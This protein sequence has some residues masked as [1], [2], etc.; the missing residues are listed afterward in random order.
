M[1]LRL[2]KELTTPG[3]SVFLWF[4]ISFLAT[5]IIFCLSLL[6]LI[7]YCQN[8][9]T[10]LELKKSSQQL[11]SGMA[12]VENTITSVL[13]SSQTLS[14]DPR[15]IPLRY[16]EPDYIS[17][18]VSVRNQMKDY[19]NG[20]VFPLPLVKDCA[21]QFTQDIAVTTHNTFF[22]DYISYYPDFFCVGDLDNEAWLALLAENK[23]GFLPVQHV[24]SKGGE[25]IRNYQEYDALIYSVPWTKSSFIYA[26]LDV[27][28]IKRALIAESD[29]ST[30]FLSLS[31]SSGS[32]LYSDCPDT[33]LSYHTIKKQSSVG[34][35]IATIH[36]PE[37]EF[38]AKMK[39]LYLF[40][41]GYCSIC[42]LVL[43]VTIIISSRISTKPLVNIIEMLEHSNQLQ[44]DETD[45]G[46]GDSASLSIK[47]GFRYIQEHFERA[48]D[49]LE[50]YHNTIHTQRRVLQARFLEKALNSQLSNARDKEMFLTYFPDFPNHFCL[51]NLRLLEQPD[52]NGSIYPDS[53][54]ILQ[55]FLQSELPGAYQQQMNDIELLLIISKGD[56]KNYIQT[57][58]YLIN[59]INHEEPSYRI[60]GIASSFYEHLENLPTAYRQLQDLNGLHFP[61]S[62]SQV[63]TFNDRPSTPED[64][65]HMADM[66]TLYTA[67]NYGNC[68]LALQR[69]KS[70]SRKLNDANR[71]IYE[72]I[73]SILVCIKM[74]HPD[75]LLSITIPD[76]S[77]SKNLYT[78]LEKTICSFCQVIQEEKHVT[79]DPFVL[80]LMDYIDKHFREYGLCLAALEE[81]FNCS[82]SKI[83]K[84]F[85]NNLQI[86]VS[87][88]IEKKRME[89]A[90]ELL[91]QKEKSITEIA[92]E[93]GFSNS[94][95]FYK[96]YQRVYGINPSAVKDSAKKNK[97]K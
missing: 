24:I 66:L 83:Q 4:L 44:P 15:F 38:T 69:L 10:E 14:K 47:Y 32:Y 36:I 26:C 27:R 33:A 37:A 72:L 6:P 30:C 48:E 2:R 12:Q 23:S 28:D 60:Y 25:S 21:L 75:S 63:C 91:F 49:Q 86:T 70:Y 22:N 74:E 8:V 67:I 68:E 84:A 52:Q 40:L 50:Q 5:S 57:L 78:I 41:G 18:D 3:R 51:V 46:K 73:R 39:P 92:L 79:T 20:L 17:I 65:F 88:Y 7:I 16:M 45:T 13:S 77:S 54:V 11:D 81:A 97:D 94:N 31:D 35:L 43:M 55:S 80:E 90:N 93:C 19:L 71:H 76:Y 29:L 9:F 82:S 62:M 87:D 58:N 61:E 56:Y 59:N 85:K 95:S 53:M 96:A 64:D 1:K 42:I 34:D 89:L